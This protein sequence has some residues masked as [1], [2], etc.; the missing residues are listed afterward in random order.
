MAAPRSGQGQHELVDDSEDAHTIQD[1][2]RFASPALE[3]GSFTLK[4]PMHLLK[5]LVAPAITAATVLCCFAVEPLPAPSNHAVYS[6]D[7]PVPNAEAAGGT[8][9]DAVFVSF[10]VPAI[11][12]SGALAFSADWK[13]AS[14]RGKVVCSNGMQVVASGD[15]VPGIDAARFES[16]SDPVAND[17]GGVAFLAKIAG[18]TVTASNNS[19]V[20]SVPSPGIPGIVIAREGGVAPGTGGATFHTFA[21]VSLIQDEV[22]F[23]AS[24]TLGTGQPVVRRLNDLGLWSTLGGD[25]EGLRVRQGDVVNGRKIFRFRALGRVLGSSAQSRTHVGRDILRVQALYTNGTNG[26]LALSS[27]GIEELAR[28]PFAVGSARVRTV[29]PPAAYDDTADFAAAVF[30]T[31]VL[32]GTGFA[33]LAGGRVAPVLVARS[34]RLAPGTD[35]ARFRSFRSPLYNGAQIAFPAWLRG[36]GVTLNNDEALYAGPVSAPALLAREGFQAPEMPAGALFQD[37][38]SLALPRVYS[39]PI[40]PGE[41]APATRGPIFTATLKIGFGNV[42]AANDRG[43]WAVDSQGLTRCL[44]REGD[45]IAGKTLKEFS[46][47]Q[48]AGISEGV[49]RAFTENY[50]V[51]WRALFTDGSSALMNTVIPTPTPTP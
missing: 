30:L 31:R 46:F 23:L 44:F 22:V 18:G 41:P 28:T 7:D 21:G 10:G 38:S 40:E 49:T 25:R 16:F 48:P 37:F 19:V 14:G 27:Q 42:T 17:E 5:S 29:G 26:V 15:P 32:P 2:R 43:A 3:S 4:R 34:G 33:V 20:V 1:E 12:V 39:G 47:L 45:T 8:P 35:G 24:L 9:T 13:S 36:R 11:S 50:S 51:A 6:K